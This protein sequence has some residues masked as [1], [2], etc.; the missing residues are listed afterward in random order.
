MKSVNQKQQKT[1]PNNPEMGEG[2]GDPFRGE[3][4]LLRSPPNK[5]GK[6]EE[7]DGGKNEETLP[8]LKQLGDIRERAG[9]LG[10]RGGVKSSPVSTKR[11][12]EEGD[13]EEEQ[14]LMDRMNKLSETINK[15]AK[16]VKESTKTRVDI[17]DTAVDIKWRMD[18]IKRK[19]SERGGLQKI[20]KKIKMDVQEKKCTK[21][22]GIQTDEIDIDNERKKVGEEMIKQVRRVLA[23]GDNLEDLKGIIDQNWQKEN[24][25]ITVMEHLNLADTRMEQDVAV[26]M[27]PKLNLQ[28]K[29]S[30]NIVNSFPGLVEIVKEELC[31]GQVEFITSNTE[32]VNRKG[33][34]V[35]NTST[36]YVLPCKMDDTGITD[37]EI[38]YDLCVSFKREAEKLNTKKNVRLL[39]WEI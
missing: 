36:I 14:E 6:E 9:S 30:E 22:M 39:C 17:R 31:E 21:T 4:T 12:R 13:E 38:L 25:K 23:E 3:R 2:D 10:S 29:K 35:I 18:G 1:K 33:N 16:L 7:Y 28:D 15:L 26:I 24:Y 8:I 32:A 5:K 37:V 34:K 27:D 11:S 20:D 19:L